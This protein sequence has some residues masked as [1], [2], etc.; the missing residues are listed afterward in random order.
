MAG[1][2]FHVFG[3]MMASISTEYYQILLSQGVCSAIGAS[4]IFQPGMILVLL[5]AQP[6]LIRLPNSSHLRQRLV[7]QEA[8]HRLRHPLYRLQRRRRHLPYHA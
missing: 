1:T 6:M 4:A 7:Q 8:R 3:L 5:S 2:F